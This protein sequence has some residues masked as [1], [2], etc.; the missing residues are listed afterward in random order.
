MDKPGYSCIL[1]V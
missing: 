1:G